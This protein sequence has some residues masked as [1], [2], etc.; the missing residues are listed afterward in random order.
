MTIN[1]ERISLGEWEFCARRR[2]EKDPVKSKILG[3][4]V[5]IVKPS[6]PGPKPIAIRLSDR[7]QQILEKIVKRQRN[8]F[9][10]TEELKQRILEFIDY[11]NQTMAKPW[12]WTYKGK[13]LQV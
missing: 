11:F 3:R 1:N 4:G 13:P 7:Q 9:S 5:K 6:M 2:T 8:S 12:K 10:S